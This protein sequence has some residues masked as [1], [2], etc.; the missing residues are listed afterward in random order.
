MYLFAIFTDMINI[1]LVYTLVLLNYSKI[2]KLKFIIYTEYIK[3]T[4]GLGLYGHY[5]Y[6]Y[7][8]GKEQ[9]NNARLFL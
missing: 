2:H 9:Y 3:L 7:R 4:L 6:L 8:A 5:N 1:K